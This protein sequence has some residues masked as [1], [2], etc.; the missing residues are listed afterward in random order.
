MDYKSLVIQASN[1]CP[2]YCPGC[3]NH[4][5]KVE[6]STEQILTFALKYKGFFNT[7]KITLSGGDPL[8][9]NDIVRL[10]DGLLDMQIEVSVD[11]VGL[12]LLK[13]NS[14]LIRV[15]KKV[16]MLGVPLDGITDSTLDSFRKGLFIAETKQVIDVAKNCSMKIC[17]NTVVHSK[18]IHEIIEI[19]EYIKTV[20]CVEKWQLFQYMPIGPRGVQ[21]A[22]VYSIPDEKFKSIE[23]DIVSY[24][25]NNQIKI[26]CKSLASRKNKYIMLGADGFIWYPRQ[27][28][29]ES[30]DFKNDSNADRI[31]VGHINNERVFDKLLGVVEI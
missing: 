7:K 2:C 12:E 30:W 3:Y 17:I 15:L 19:A 27:T 9:R 23:K 8:L 6:I 10:I 31:I 29:K 26:E 13:R 24:I 16:N 22:R 14:E 11:T 4:F 28:D 5:S 25:F 18:N 21:N 20:G 1:R